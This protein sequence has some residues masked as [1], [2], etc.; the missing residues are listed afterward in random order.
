M[1]AIYDQMILRNDPNFRDFVHAAVL[2]VATEIQAEASTVQYHVARLAIAD[3]I[4]K[5]DEPV[6]IAFLNRIIFRGIMYPAI[7]NSVVQDGQVA[8]AFADDETVL[9]GVRAIWNETAFAVWPTIIE[10]T[11]TPTA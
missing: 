3:K 5:T 8:L 7:R 10:D 2:Q 9:N 6:V 11:K 1:G 4:I